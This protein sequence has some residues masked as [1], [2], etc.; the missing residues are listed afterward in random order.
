MKALPPT[1]TVRAIRRLRHATTERFDSDAHDAL[2]GVERRW[3]LWLHDRALQ[4]DVQVRRYLS[5]A[6]PE[7]CD[8][9]LLRRRGERW[10]VVEHI[11]PPTIL[12]STSAREHLRA[13]SNECRAIPSNSMY[14]IYLPDHVGA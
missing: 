6:A 5:T 12:I 4:D 9:E 11:E 13:V 2:A 7:M 3:L 14:G 8:R 10:Y 1:A